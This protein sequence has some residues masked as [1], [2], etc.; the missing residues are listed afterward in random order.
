M[1]E[2]DKEADIIEELTAEVLRKS[3][4][5]NCGNQYDSD[6]ENIWIEISMQ[7]RT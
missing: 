4:P 1:L 5:E 2:S 7:Q 3:L 6:V